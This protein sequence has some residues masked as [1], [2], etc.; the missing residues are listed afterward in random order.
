MEGNNDIQKQKEEF[1]AK[2][3]Q[4]AKENGFNLNPDTKTVERVVNGIF[5]NEEKYG[6]KYCPCRRVTGNTEEDANKIC[7][8]IWHKDEIAK[9]GKCFCG[10]FVKK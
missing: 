8:C 9:D 7:P 2:S 4:Y 1:I 6:K 3:A 10:L 5:M